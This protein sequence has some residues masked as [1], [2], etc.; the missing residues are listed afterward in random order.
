MPGP[1]PTSHPCLPLAFLE[2]A[3][4]MVRQR[5]MTLPVRQRAVLVFLRPAQPLLSH[6]AAGR[7]AQRP[8]AAVRHGR[9]RWSQGDFAREDEP[10][11]GRHAVFA[12]AGAGR[13]QS[14]GG[15]VG[16]APPSTL[17]PPVVGGRAWSRAPGM[18][19]AEQPEDGRAH[20]GGR[21]AQTLAGPGLDVSPCSALRRDSWARPGA[22]RGPV[23]GPTSGPPGSQDSCRGADP[24]PS[25]APV[26]S[27][28]ATR[29]RAGGLQRMRGRAWRR[30]AR[31]GGVGCAPWR[32]S[33][34]LRTTP[35]ERAVWATRGP[36]DAPGTLPRGSAD[37]RGGGPRVVPAWAR[38]V[39]AAH[40]GLAHP[41]RGP[42]PWP[43]PWA[44]SGSNLLGPSAA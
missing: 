44:H 35:R 6:G 20:G 30:V 18:R 3:R 7:W 14:P 11:R 27:K 10:G 16:L 37:L 21:G 15:C 12:P 33:G 34:T 13:C 38:R 19:P 29:S 43:C 25:P 23:G 31:P 22:A 36:S 42:Y 28:P 39:P 1:S 4:Q 5:P 40:A 32:R 41:A 26:P 9:R 8:P 24:Y 2:Q 17:A